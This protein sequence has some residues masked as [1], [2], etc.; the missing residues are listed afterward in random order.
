MF[1]LTRREGVV[2]RHDDGGIVGQ[3]SG[4]GGGVERDQREGAVAGEGWMK[5][6]EGGSVRGSGSGVQRSRER[7]GQWNPLDEA[8]IQ[9][10]ML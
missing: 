1:P 9:L 5:Q 8:R 4:G 7:G 2:W 10:R 6:K 3:V